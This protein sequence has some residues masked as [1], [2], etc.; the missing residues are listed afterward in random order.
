[1]SI[2]HHPPATGAACW[3]DGDDPGDRRFA[4]LGELTLESGVRLPEVTLAYETWGR[5][6][7][8]GDN[9]VLVEHALT[10]DSHVAGGVGPGHPTPGWWTDLVGPGLPLDTDRWFVVAPNVLGGCQGSTGPSSPAP[11]GRPWGSR[12]PQVTVRDQVAAEARLAEQLGLRRWRAVL[13]GS[14]GGMR[15][16]EWVTSHPDRLR[17]ALVLAS[18][19]YASAEQIGWSQA[20]ILAIRNDPDFA[21]GDYYGTGRTPEAGLAIARR[22]AHVT[23]R[24]ELE[25]HERFGR[26]EQ[27]GGAGRR[28]AVESYLDHH[29]AKLAARFD[30][31]S[32]IALSEAMNSHDVGRGRGGLQAALAPFAGRLVVAPID[33][34]RLYPPRL[35]EEIVAASPSAELRPVRSLVG[36]DAFL[37]ESD[38]VGRIIRDL[39]G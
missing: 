19:G 20:Q 38:Q 13:G 1:M 16:L 17:A 10:G 32:Y 30:A 31:N 37:T 6:S 14:M 18:T 5:L 12:F 22:I 23:Y 36:H 21:D 4:H 39:L 34:D 15:S 11:D 29:G 26:E 8:S 3:R 2:T 27:P 35:S 7:P 28:F 24:S 9:A 33:S 25:L